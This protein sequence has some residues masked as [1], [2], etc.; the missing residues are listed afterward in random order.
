MSTIGNKAPVSPVDA[1]S[2]SGAG[3]DSSIGVSPRKQARKRVDE[4]R[5]RL[6]GVLDKE[7]LAAWT[8]EDILLYDKTGAHVPTVAG[9]W[10]R[11]RRR[12]RDLKKWLPQELKEALKRTIQ[13][14][15]GIYDDDLYE[16]LISRYKLPGNWEYEDVS[17]YLET[18][19]K[20]EYTSTGLLINDRC[21]R[22]KKLEHWT[23]KEIKAAIAGLITAPFPVDELFNTL[24]YRQGLSNA[25]PNEFLLK[26][27][28][29]TTESTLDNILLKARLEEYKA[30]RTKPGA[31]LTEA[32]IG[33]AQ[34]TLYDVIR[35]VMKRPHSEFREGWTIILDFVNE[36]HAKL[37]EGSRAFVGWS[38]IGVRASAA[39]TF[40][41]LLTL[42]V[43]TAKPSERMSGAK[44]YRLDTILQYVSSE[45]ERENVIAFY[46]AS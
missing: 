34:D 33:K 42:I 40:E 31:K 8:D 11:D 23:G 4:V 22:Q 44:P 39:A 38:Q 7:R 20:P 26:N 14:P 30:T 25:Y 24:K 32:T 9:V 45:R 17:T 21:R 36:N 12:T 16:E 19:K 2:E 28:D 15:K 43:A 1:N 10:F 18:G 29:V 41:D 27:L 37:F 3:T 6:V 46:T 35:R 5:D 13:F